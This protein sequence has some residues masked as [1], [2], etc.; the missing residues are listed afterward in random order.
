MTHTICPQCAAPIEQSPG[1]VPWCAG[2]NWNLRPAQPADG[3]RLLGRFFTDLGR[4]SGQQLFRELVQAAS[5]NPTPNRARVLTVFLAGLVHGLSLGLAIFG[6]G[7]IVITWLQLFPLALGLLLIGMAWVLRPRIPRLADKPLPRDQFPALYGVMDRI[8]G[9]IGARPAAH[10]VIDE[11]FNASYSQVGWRQQPVIALG[12]PLLGV[13]DAQGKIAL[14]GH[15]LAHGVNADLTRSLFV[16]SAVEALQGWYDL[17]HPRAL[18]EPER[19]LMAYPILLANLLQL[20]VAQL[21]L[22]AT[23]LLSV[24]VWR[25]SQRAEYQADALAAAVAGTSAKLGLLEAILLGTT[26][27]TVVRRLALGKGEIGL[28]DALGQAVAELPAHERDRLR[29]VSR[30]DESRLDSTHPPTAQRIAMLEAR[31]A[32]AP[33]IELSP[34]ELAAIDGELRRLEPA[35]TRRLI[36]RYRSH[37][38]S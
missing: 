17:L 28:I 38:Y 5:L 9:S 14:I 30:L 22:G 8:G 31:P 6:A 32:A 12:L 11:A 7:L 1:Y 13:L 27:E 24:L 21:A 35:I 10:L 15:E 37:L 29:R 20:G 34:A 19:G 4:R 36:D 33:L 2:C 16:G 3:P 18:W 26:V 23:Y 25:D